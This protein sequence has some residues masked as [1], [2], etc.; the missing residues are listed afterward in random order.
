MDV[1]TK[2]GHFHH[3]IC[4]YTRKRRKEVLKLAKYISCDPIAMAVALDEPGMVTSRDTQYCTVE[5]HGELTRGQMVVDWNQ[6]LKRDP[7]VDI[8]TGVN[9][10]RLQQ[11]YEESLK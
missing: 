11:L 8:I 6:L 9:L 3:K 5:L 1:D 2:K 10:D 4:E 7:N